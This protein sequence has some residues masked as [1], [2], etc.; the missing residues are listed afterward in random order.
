MPDKLLTVAE[1][2]HRLGVNEAEVHRLVHSGA[3]K[4]LR[5]GGELLRFHPDDLAAYQARA[6]GRLVATRHNTADLTE[7]SRPSRVA[8]AWDRC[9][10]FVYTYD[11]YLLAFALVAVIL[12]VIVLMQR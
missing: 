7:V 12:A 6:K 10:E 4:A 5:L 9:W 2:A 3:L 1:T 11:F 8:A